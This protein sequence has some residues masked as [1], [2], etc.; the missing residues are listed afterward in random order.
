MLYSVFPSSSDTS[1]LKSAVYREGNYLIYKDKVIDV[2]S[3]IKFSDVVR[4]YKNVFLLYDYNTN[5]WVLSRI[6]VP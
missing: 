5:Q 4:V 2:S 1:D 3:P 6:V